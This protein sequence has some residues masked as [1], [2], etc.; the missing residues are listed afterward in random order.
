MWDFG[1]KFY[2]KRIENK[3]SYSKFLE[4]LEYDLLKIRDCGHL[5][6]AI[7]Q[8]CVYVLLNGILKQLMWTE[9]LDGYLYQKIIS[10]ITC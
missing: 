3:I 4:D 9:D 1:S 7:K 2:R 6:L 10:K 8:C 5:P